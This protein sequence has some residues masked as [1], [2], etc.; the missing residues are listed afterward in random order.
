V[1]V[2]FPPLFPFPPPTEDFSMKAD[3]FSSNRIKDSLYRWFEPPFLPPPLLVRKPSLF[4]ISSS[5]PRLRG[6]SK[7]SRKMP[8]P[9]PPPSSLLNA[10]WLALRMLFPPFLRDAK[11][12]PSPPE[13][14]P[15][16]QE[17]ISPF[18]KVSHSE[19]EEK[20][21]LFPPSRCFA[22]LGRL[23]SYFFSLFVLCPF[24]L[25]FSFPSLRNKPSAGDDFVPLFRESY[26]KPFS[27]PFSTAIEAPL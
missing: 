26:E 2:A 19:L 5:P 6:P 20:L 10:S 4:P 8:P 24:S 21:S 13:Y 15:F 18:G 27:F 7:D 22:V 25:L 23:I 3:L 16:F 12:F 14:Y 11:P 17:G 9:G 1:G